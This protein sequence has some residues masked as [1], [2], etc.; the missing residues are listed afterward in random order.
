MKK[1]FIATLAVLFIA[2]VAYA[3]V[4]TMDFTGMFYVRGSYI[5][6]DSGVEEDAGNYMY[7]DQELDADWKISASDK[8]FVSVNFEARDQNWLAGNTRRYHSR[9]R[10]RSGRQP[11]DQAALGPTHL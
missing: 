3:G 1:L 11:G 2:G 6:N 5:S 10:I 4:P 8:T 7:Y 9:R